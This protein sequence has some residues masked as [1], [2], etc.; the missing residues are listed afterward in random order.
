MLRSSR[1]TFQSTFSAF[2]SIICHNMLITYTWKSKATI[3]ENS[4]PG[5]WADQFY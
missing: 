5:D 2:F 1:R 4:Y 3:T